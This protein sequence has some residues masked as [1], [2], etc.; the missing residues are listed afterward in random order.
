MTRTQTRTN[1]HRSSLVRILADLGLV[2]T[3]APSGAFA[4]QL[5]QWIDISSAIDLR[6]AH[7]ASP[8]ARSTSSVAPALETELARLRSALEAAI[9]RRPAPGAART[10]MD[11]PWPKPGAPLE[12]ASAYEPYRRYY[13]AQQ[14]DIDLK[15]PPL[16]SRIREALAGASPALGQLAALDAALDGVLS[17]REGPLLA[18]LPGLLEKHFKQLQQQH[19]ERLNAA[20]QADNP[21]HWM[22]QGGWLAGFCNALQS[23]LLAELELRLQPSLGLLEALNSTTTKSI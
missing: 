4:E 1:L 15:I 3:A 7:M 11:M 6:A 17:A 16:R 9:T 22:D 2:D 14:R 12:W 13:L 23:L 5:S 18:S 10:R 20:Q 8:V 19:L 21:D